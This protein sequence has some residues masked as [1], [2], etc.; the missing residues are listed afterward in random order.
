[1][2]YRHCLTAR[3]TVAARD[4]N[5][6][7]IER[8]RSRSGARD[9][10]RGGIGKLLGDSSHGEWL[11]CTRTHALRKGV[12]QREVLVGDVDATAE[13]VI[14]HQE[15][16]CQRLAAHDVERLLAQRAAIAQPADI[17]RLRLRR[18]PGASPRLQCPD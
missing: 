9:E 10:Q 18:T 11:L 2:E 14:A 16:A 12:K 13:H 6:T 8:N 15:A 3:L 5:L 4:D 7:G 1:L 17:N